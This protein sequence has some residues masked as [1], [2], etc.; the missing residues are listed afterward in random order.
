MA[1]YKPL[2]DFLGSQEKETVTLSFA[3]IEKIVGRP[4]PQSAYRW[5]WWWKDED[6]S[7]TRHVQ[8]KAWTRQGF[9]AHVD[10]TRH[11]VEFRWGNVG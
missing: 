6:T 3:D 11:V 4:L 5:D 8:S 2:E 9:S 10:R 1:T 7:T